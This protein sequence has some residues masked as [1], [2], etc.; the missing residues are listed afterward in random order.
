MFRS[1]R[2]RPRRRGFTLIE[3]LL[4]L[5]ILV[6]VG[7]V[8]VMNYFGVFA[9]SKIDA[10]KVQIKAFI[11][12][13]RIFRLQQNDYPPTEQGLNALLLPMTTPDGRTTG[14]YYIEPP[15]KPDPW[16]HPYLYQYPS[17]HGL[18]VPDVWSCGPDGVPNT[19]DDIG[20]WE[21]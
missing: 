7:S 5:A 6:I 8:A 12:P 21:F 19:Q 10:A 14:G 2:S 18:D 9:A 1:S 20:N 4:V 13:L 11:E 3:V 16:G 17:T 15:L